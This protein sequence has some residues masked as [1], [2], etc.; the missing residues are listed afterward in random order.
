MPQHR[1]ASSTNTGSSRA[2]SKA[3]SG[4]TE[5]EAEEIKSLLGYVR[6]VAEFA[7]KDD[8]LLRGHRCASW[9]ATPSLGRIVPRSDIDV[10]DMEAE[11]VR[12]FKRKC[13]P[14]LNR[15]LTSEWDILSIAQ[16]HG[17]P[18]RLLDWTAN[19]LAALWFAVREP[20]LN[21]QPAEVLIFAPRPAD[22]VNVED[23]S[24]YDVP[25]TLFFQPSHSN[26][27]IAAQQ[28][29]FS[30]HKWNA[31]KGRFSRVEQLVQYRRRITR[32]R[33]PADCFADIRWDLDRMA[34]N[35]ATLFPDLDGLSRHLRWSFSLLS[36]EFS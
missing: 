4:R 17:L 21:E 10:I 30:V 9:E 16:H 5:V 29:W 3:I 2:S 25:R 33:I 18:T 28:G 14:F 8:L 12:D 23:V 24:P 7:D 36:D 22:Y 1:A 26:A 32:V 35:D 31:S 11:M 20:P 15:E 34:I 27:R 13:V 19:P 6:A